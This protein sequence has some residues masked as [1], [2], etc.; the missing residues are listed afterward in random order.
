MTA[1]N[2]APFWGENSGAV[3]KYFI[4]EIVFAQHVD[5]GPSDRGMGGYCFQQFFSRLDIFRLAQL[6]GQVEIIPTNNAV[7]DNTVTSLGDFLIFLCSLGIFPCISDRDCACE[8][9]CQFDFVELRLDGLAKFKIIDVS[10]DKE[11]LHNLPKGLHGFIKTVLARIR[12]QPPK[13]VRCRCFLELYGGHQ[14]QDCVPVF[15][16]DILIDVFVW[17][18]GPFGGCP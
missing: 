5:M 13:D 2:G 14:P 16:Y 3:L 7:F 4:G 8:P 12:I 18:D 1:S 10:Q 9:V 15:N 17:P 6:A 11:G